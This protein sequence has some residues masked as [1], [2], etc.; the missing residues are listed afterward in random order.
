MELKKREG[1]YVGG[2]ENYT[3]LQT[4]QRVDC[5][6]FCGPNEFVAMYASFVRVYARNEARS[7]GGVQAHRH[8]SSPTKGAQQSLP[9]RKAR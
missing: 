2:F 1:M 8:P 3:S 4:D 7:E 6:R 9:Q 5:K